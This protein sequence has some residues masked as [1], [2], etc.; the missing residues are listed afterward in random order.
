MR[1]QNIHNNDSEIIIFERDENG[2]QSIC[3]KKDFFPYFYEPAQEVGTYTTYDR[4]KARIVYCT[5]PNE[6]KKKRSDYSYE[7]DVLFVKRYIID[8]IEK[9]EKTKLRYMM[10]DIEIKTED[11]PKPKE[12]KKADGMITCITTYDNLKN[13]Y[14][15]FYIE[16]YSS[17]YEMLDAFCK[18]VK[19]TAPDILLGWN[20]LDFDYPYLFYRIPDFAQKIS[21]IGQVR[22]IE[23]DYYYP[24]G[25]SI[26]DFLGLYHKFT[27]GKKDSYALDV[28]A[29]D[30]LGYESWGE[31]DF[32]ND[33]EHVKEKNI[34]DVKK[35]VELQH[36]NN[37]LEFYDEIRIL[38]TCLWED[39][40]PIRNDYGGWQSNNS[41][42]IDMLILREAKKLGVVLPKKPSDNELESFEGAYREAFKTG[43]FF[44]ITKYDLGS[45][46]PT[47]IMDFKLDP[48]NVRETKE[49]N[50]VKLDIKARED[51][52]ITD[53]YYFKQN[54][55]VTLPSAVRRLIVIKNDL[56]AKVKA[57]P[58]ES[59]EYKIVNIAYDSI[60][61]VINSAY[62]VMGNRFFRMYDKRV[63][64]TTTF[65]V[66]DVLQYVQ[67]EIEQRGY[68]VIY[69][70]T[71]SLFVNTA[72][73]INPLLNELI[74]KW[75]KEKY[76]KE[77]ISL[78]F[79]YEGKFEKLLILAKCR[80]IGYIEKKGKIE[81][82]IKGVEVKRKDST[83]YMKAFQ[84]NLI[85]L[86]LNKTSKE[87]VIKWIDLKLSTFRDEPITDI[88][89]PCKVGRKDYK[90]IPVFVRALENTQQIIDFKKRIGEKFYY[91]Y[92]IPTKKDGEKAKEY[93][94][95]DVLAFD[96]KVQEHV[97]LIN[98]EKM[99]DRNIFN[100]VEVIL[101]AMN[102]ID[103]FEE[104]RNKYIN[105]KKKR[106]SKSLAECGNS[107]EEDEE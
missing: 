75:G 49:E 21:P 84:D 63:A 14:K 99:M 16:D 64:E 11:L 66:R 40:Q 51:S 60:K 83:K 88:A 35:M 46:Y 97:D 47:M 44:N 23:K 71:D 17:E 32:A 79:D 104:I 62:G 24:A 101:E 95:R 15:T 65:L 54:D 48:A 39:L 57:T 96:A 100:K 3:R 38:S 1:L 6:V 91:I 31:T 94:K 10:L 82:E 5:K 74:T 105:P 80:Y 70:D 98:Y 29:Q 36:K 69:V 56:K 78:K 30:E 45:A 103:E 72:E 25:I 34:L 90:N 20:M 8:K 22:Y 102:W 67:H 106:K 19:D 43:A 87:E 26:L 92:V 9:I 107:N 2:K 52:N 18:Y 81:K 85:D 53:T 42:I 50:C 68:E 27:L 55:K 86:I 61:S 59:E 13:E 37:I 89:V 76:G 28:V 12:E 93:N 73:N 4:K 33:L 77:D 41:K 7:S 58:Q